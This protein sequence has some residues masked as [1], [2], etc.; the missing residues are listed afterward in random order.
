VNSATLPES[1]RTKAK[2]AVEPALD[3]DL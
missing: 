3:F 2:F 1:S